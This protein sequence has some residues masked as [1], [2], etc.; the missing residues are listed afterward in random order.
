VQSHPGDAIALKH[1]G[2][3]YKVQWTPLTSLNNATTVS[4]SFFARG[5][6]SIARSITLFL[7]CTPESPHFSQFHSSPSALSPNV[8]Q[9]TSILN[10]QH[11][12]YHQLLLPYNDKFESFPIDSRGMRNGTFPYFPHYPKPVQKYAGSTYNQG[13]PLPRHAGPG[14]GAIDIR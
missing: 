13:E 12:F 2:R 10:I 7:S 9:P 4:S 14:H 3:V 5:M 8:S 6:R 1:Q 11:L